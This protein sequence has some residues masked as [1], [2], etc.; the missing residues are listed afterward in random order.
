MQLLSS[1]GTTQ[2][3]ISQ[4]GGTSSETI[5]RTYTAGT[6]YLRVYGY[7]GANSATSCYTLKVQLGTASREENLI[8]SDKISVFPN[9]VSG[10]L[11]VQSDGISGMAE[12]RIFDVYGKMVMQQRSASIKTQLD[13]SKLPAG[14]YMVKVKDDKKEISTKIVKE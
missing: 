8:V 14:V 4:N 5:S 10:V 9:P 2:L 12:I 3:A 11:T 1:N 13:V 6:Y 7:N